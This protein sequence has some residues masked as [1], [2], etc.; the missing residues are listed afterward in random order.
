MNKKDLRKKANALAR[1]LRQRS[2]EICRDNECG[3]EH[4]CE[5]YAYIDGEMNLLDLCGSDYFQGTSKP[6]AAISLPWCE[7]GGELLDAVLD[8]CAE[9]V[10]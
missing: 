1:Y 4:N 7:F 8:Q 9:M 3:E 6:H 2:K 10:D 5:S